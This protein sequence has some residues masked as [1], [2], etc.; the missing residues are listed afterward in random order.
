MDFLHEQLS[1]VNQEVVELI[2][3]DE[4]FSIASEPCLDLAVAQ[5]VPEVDVE[6]LTCA[7]VHHVVTGVAISN[8]KHIRRDALP[9]Q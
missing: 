2:A 5:E 1:K 9:S 8:S 4:R 3:V 6:E 7:V